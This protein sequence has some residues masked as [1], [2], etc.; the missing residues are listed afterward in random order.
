MKIRMF[1]FYQKIV[2]LNNRETF[3]YISSMLYQVLRFNKDLY[4]ATNKSKTIA[5][6]YVSAKKREKISLF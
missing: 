1:S 6:S 3:V 4:I 2:L 5:I